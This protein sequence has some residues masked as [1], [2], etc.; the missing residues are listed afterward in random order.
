MKKQLAIITCLSVL[1]F[2]AAFSL[3]YLCNDHDEYTSNY[4]DEE[5]EQMLR[6]SS[7]T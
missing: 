4:S 7:R 5:I 6:R 2:V 1:L 3:I